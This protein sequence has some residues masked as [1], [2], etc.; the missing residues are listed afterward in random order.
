MLNS[1]PAMRSAQR[2][3]SRKIVELMGLPAYRTLFDEL[4][5]DLHGH[6]NSS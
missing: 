6:Q 1:G 4:M 5:A 3:I 2:R